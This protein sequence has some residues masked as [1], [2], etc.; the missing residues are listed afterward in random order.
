MPFE[1]Y[2]QKLSYT[3][4][5]VVICITS[6][7]CYNCKSN[8]IMTT[9]DNSTKQ[10]TQL[11]AERLGRHGPSRPEND[12]FPYNHEPVH[13]PESRA[14]YD[15]EVEMELEREHLSSGTIRGIAGAGEAGNLDDWDECL[16]VPN[17]PG[18]PTGILEEPSRVVRPPGQPRSAP[19]EAELC[20]RD[21]AQTPLREVCSV[22]SKQRAKGQKR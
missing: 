20:G 11:N 13:Y 16:V 12:L 21:I 1:F 18:S 9:Q 5:T 8:C 17:Q 7:H 10:Y 4:N 2:A 15:V 14:Q 22:A 3:E 6:L 19:T